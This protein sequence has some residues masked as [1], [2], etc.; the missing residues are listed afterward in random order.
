MYR[1]RRNQPSG[2]HQTSG[3][4][5]T[6]HCRKHDYVYYPS[7]WIDSDTN[8]EYKAGYYDEDGNFYEK[9]DFVNGA[10][11]QVSYICE[12]CGYSTRFKKQGTIDTTCPKCGASMVRDE[13]VPEDEILTEGISSG[14][15]GSSVFGDTGL[16]KKVGIIFFI[17]IG[18]NA[19]MAFTTGLFTHD[20]YSSYSYSNSYSNSYS[21]EDE[22][23][24]V[25]EIGRTCPLIGE[26]YYDAVTDCYFWFN[27]YIDPPQW[28]YWYEGISSDYG[29]YGWMEYDVNEDTWYIE[30]SDSNWEVLPDKYDTSELW[31]INE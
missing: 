20:D 5:I 27:D 22:S 13:S 31:Y 4:A 3:R 6:H 19:V 17:V 12:Y 14:G 28:H 18:I 7:S 2:Y 21:S 1:S 15:S 29:D 10:D 9:V 11:A 30:V 23:I 26:N 8:R 16:P 25:E 24:Y